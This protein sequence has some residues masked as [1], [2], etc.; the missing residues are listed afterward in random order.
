MSRTY[1]VTG[2]ASGIGKATAEQL[3]SHG[4]TVITVDIK[5][6]DVVADLSTAEGR[7]TYAAQVAELSGGTV[8]GVVAVAGLVIPKPVTVSVNFFGAIATLEAIKPLLLASPS[9]RAAIVASLAALGEPDQGL[10]DALLAGDEAAALLEAERVGES[11]DPS[12]NNVIY[13]TTKYAVARWIRQYG[14]SPEWAG[15][16]IALNGIAPGVIVTPMTKPAL[17]TEEGRKVMAAGAPAPL[18]GPAGAP[19]AVAGLLEYL[20]S[21]ENSFIAGQIIFIDGGAEA[22]ARPEVV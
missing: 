4:H 18:N 2:A 16:G 15:E 9:P 14:T 20:V 22:L 7:E 13:T 6:A 11:A 8:D 1:V 3:K 5:D 19:E 12:G 21:E 17:E 10:L